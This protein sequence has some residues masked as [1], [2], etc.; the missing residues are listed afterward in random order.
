MSLY[1]WI[2]GYKFCNPDKDESYLNT[3]TDEQKRIC[4][5]I[6][7]LTA[8][9]RDDWND[10]EDRL[11]AIK[12][13]CEKLA[14]TE[15]LEQLEENTDAIYYDGRW[16]RDVWDGPYENVICTRENVGDKLYDQYADYLH[17]HTEDTDD[18]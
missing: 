7:I 10:I 9:I 12:E 5:M 4:L 13:L 2:N 8:D 1:S 11:G 15:W 14:K 16:F 6:G 3:M 17:F 18:E